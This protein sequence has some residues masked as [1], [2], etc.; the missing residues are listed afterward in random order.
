MTQ[1]KKTEGIG[2]STIQ[3]IPV[4]DEAIRKLGVPFSK[5]LSE[6]VGGCPPGEELLFP[7]GR[8]GP[9]GVLTLLPAPRV[10]KSSPAPQVSC[11]A[12]RP[13]LACV[14]TSA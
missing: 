4:W 11:C 13:E 6:E 9:E 14:S 1:S 5:D 2:K 12:H 7:E 10:C 3:V 8:A